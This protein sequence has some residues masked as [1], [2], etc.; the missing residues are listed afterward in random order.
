MTWNRKAGRPFIARMVT[1]Q[2]TFNCAYETLSDSLSPLY[3]SHDV[4]AICSLKT[5]F[6]MT[7]SHVLP[8][9]D[10]QREDILELES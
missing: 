3:S 2:E 1:I 7:T 8:S 9:T 10:Y 6:R 5:C 4:G